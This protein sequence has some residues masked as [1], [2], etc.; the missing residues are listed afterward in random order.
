MSAFSSFFAM[1][2]QLFSAITVLFTA[3]EHLA[4]AALSLS[5]VASETAGA[6]EDTSRSDRIKA[7]RLLQQ[8][9]GIELIQAPVKQVK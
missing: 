9:S 3:S 2:K 7:A 4:K 5:I 6:Y 8:E 1:F